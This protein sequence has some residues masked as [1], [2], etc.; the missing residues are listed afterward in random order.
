M[1]A[2][3]TRRKTKP[4]GPEGASA[5]KFTPDGKRRAIDP[6]RIAADLSLKRIRVI[7]KVTTITYDGEYSAQME[8]TAK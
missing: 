4:T 5:V 2:R 7:S 6:G 8:Y 1:A 3:K